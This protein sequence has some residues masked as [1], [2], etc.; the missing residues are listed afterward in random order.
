MVIVFVRFLLSGNP[1][2]K[3]L[4]VGL[5]VAVILDPT[6]ERCLLVP[7]AM[8]RLGRENWDMLRWRHRLVRNVNIGG[9]GFFDRPGRPARAAACVLEP[10]PVA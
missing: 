9:S 5:G 4:R 6:V 1:T 8:I 3:P 10:G 7:T 2:V